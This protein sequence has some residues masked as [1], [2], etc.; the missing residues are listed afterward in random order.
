MAY[1]KIIVEINLGPDYDLQPKYMQKF[2]VRSIVRAV[3]TLPF[4]YHC[5]VAPLQLV[6]QVVVP[7]RHV[8]VGLTVKTPCTSCKC[9]SSLESK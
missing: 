9:V 1:H 7:N 6:Q 5:H 4:V 3:K 2:M 8:A